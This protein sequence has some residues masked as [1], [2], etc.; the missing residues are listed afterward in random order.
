MANQRNEPSTGDLVAVAKALADPGRLRVLLALRHRELC[1]CQIVELLNLASSTVSRHMA[2]LRQA[3]LV[4]SR[5]DGRWIYYRRPGREAPPWVRSA[6][7]WADRAAGD[8]QRTD[9][10]RLQ[11]I[12]ERT[13]VALCKRQGRS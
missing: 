8:R 10:R 13:P 12:L 7:A 1:V 4:R 6:I 9:D 11:R 2:V 3:G 5:K